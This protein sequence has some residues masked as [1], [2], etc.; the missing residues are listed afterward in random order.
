M[1]TKPG[2]YDLHQPAWSER[3]TYKDVVAPQRWADVRVHLGWLVFAEPLMKT[4]L[5]RRCHRRR[6]PMLDIPE[7]GVL[8]GP[9]Y[10]GVCALV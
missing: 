9:T 1:D 5:F 7:D 2:S 3:A 8:I 10:L 6:M 4:R